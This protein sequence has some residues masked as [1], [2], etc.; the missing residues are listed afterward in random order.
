MIVTPLMLKSLDNLN[1][2]F[3]YLW[4]SPLEWNSIKKQFE[5]NKASLKLVPCFIVTFLCSFGLSYIPISALS[6]A[7][8]FGHLNL[9]A[10]ICIFYAICLLLMSV[11]LTSELIAA[12]FGHPISVGLNFLVA[13][14]RRIRKS[15]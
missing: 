1:K 13:V 12:V 8:L 7:K 14:E 3:F 6:F 2:A 5:Y 10:A 9:S 4:L 11:T 15:K